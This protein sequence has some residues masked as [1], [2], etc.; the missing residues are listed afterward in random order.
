MPSVRSSLLT[1]NNMNRIYRYCN[2]RRTRYWTALYFVAYLALGWALYALYEGGYFT[3]WFASSIG[4]LLILMALSIPRRLELTADKVRVV[5]LLDMTE[6]PYVDIA[7]VRRVEEEDKRLIIPIFGGC[8]FFGY[9]GHFIDLKRFDR[10]LIYASEWR[11]LVEITTI[12]E[13][14]LWLSC[15]EADELVAAI[16]IAVEEA[17]S[18]SQQEA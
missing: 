17:R 18:E 10:L 6:V 2:D 15:S 7:S 9:Y 5:C 12:Y 11:N 8:G 13:E 14:H 16:R 4:A 3:A 1:I